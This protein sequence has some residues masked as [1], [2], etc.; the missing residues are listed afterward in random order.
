MGLFITGPILLTVFWLVTVIWLRRVPFWLVPCEFV[1]TL[2]VF[3]L[4][5]VLMQLDGN[6]GIDAAFSDS[7]VQPSHW[8]NLAGRWGFY[9]FTD[10]FS[11]TLW[12]LVLAIVSV[13][14]GLLLAHRKLILA[15]LKGGSQG[16][17]HSVDWEW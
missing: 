15:T 13:P 9:L 17:A 6:A 2:V 5:M 7:T 8:Q 4:A 16:A 14:I 12:C 3:G 11:G 10:S 1:F